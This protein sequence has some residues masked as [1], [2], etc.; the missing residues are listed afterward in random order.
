MKAGG[1]GGRET[2]G[3]RNIGTSENQNLETQKKKG[4]GNGRDE[5][6]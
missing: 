5:E 6:L 1:E 4:R 2:S 3:N